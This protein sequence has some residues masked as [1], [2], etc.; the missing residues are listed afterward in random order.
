VSNSTLAAR[1]SALIDKWNG[2][3]N[4]LRDMLTQQTGTVDME[5]GTGAIVTLPTFP[6]LQK[7]VTGLTDDLTGA[8]AKAAAASSQASA[9][10]SASLKSANDSDTARAAAVV[11]KDAA[12]ASAVAA[13]TSATTTITKAGDAAASATQAGT[14]AAAADASAVAAA[15]S[16]STVK[17]YSDNAA[18]SATAADAS[19]TAAAASQGLAL[20]YAIGAL[21]Y[22]G[23]WSAASGATPASPKTGDFYI[24]SV[25]GTVSSVKYGVGDMLV[26]DGDAWDRIDNQTAV[27]TVAGRTGNVVIAISDLAGLQAALDAKQNLLGFTAVQQGTGIGQGANLIKLGWGSSKLKLT[28]DNTD[29]GSIATESWAVSAFPLIAG[30]TV[31]TNT[32]FASGSPPN[33]AALVNNQNV[34]FTI[35]NA[36]NNS[37]SAV[38]GFLRDGQFGAFFGL[39]T[40]NQWKVGGWSTG[41]VA[42]RVIHEGLTNWNCPGQLGAGN[43]MLTNGVYIYQ[44]ANSLNIRCGPASSYRYHQFN[45]V[46]DL[47]ISAWAYA[48][49]FKISSDARLKSNRVVLDAS[50]ELEKLKRLIP[51]EY[52]KDG[53]HEYGFFAQEVEPVYPTMVTKNPGQAG[54]DTRSLSATELLAP[55]VAVLQDFDRRLTKAGL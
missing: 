7:T 54:K 20:Q 40:D 53:N 32:V 11:A 43:I 22:R 17:T 2:Y 35:A 12:A 31:T 18:T 38:M 44:S 47:M 21:I 10:A 23:K 9:F 8:A 3:K 6:A 39:D 46:G 51:C 15:G 34:A 26:Y 16:L 55:I 27:N 50:T 29:I 13:D 41:A 36:N 1:I 49:N 42:Y 28:V 30:R 24:V 5:D 14:K 37:A 25:A 48:A 45:D 52:D 19:K 33:I 4:A